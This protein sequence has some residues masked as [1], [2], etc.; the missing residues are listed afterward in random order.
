MD[1]FLDGGRRGNRDAAKFLKPIIQERIDCMKKY[2]DDWS[3]KPVSMH[4][5]FMVLGDPDV[6]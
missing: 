4:I 5:M 1:Y 3:D 6:V 2:G